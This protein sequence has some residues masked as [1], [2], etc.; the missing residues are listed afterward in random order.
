MNLIEDELHF[1]SHERKP[2]NGIDIRIILKLNR[3]E[4]GHRI[5]YER[6]ELNSTFYVDYYLIRARNKISYIIRPLKINFL[7]IS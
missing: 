7:N 2:I 5:F 1:S 3:K 6:C 4:L